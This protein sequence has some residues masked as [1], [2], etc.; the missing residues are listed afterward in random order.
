MFFGI[1]YPPLLLNIFVPME[2]SFGIGMANITL[3]HFGSAGIAL[4]AVI[5]IQAPPANQALRKSSNRV[6]LFCCERKHTACQ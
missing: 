1:L 3:V 4:G 6:E 2:V 5:Q